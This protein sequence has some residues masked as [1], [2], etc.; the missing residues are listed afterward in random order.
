MIKK[1]GKI[2]SNGF[3]LVEVVIAISILVII[4][5]TAY[6]AITQIIST[7]K[8]LD[9]KR[10]LSI[11]ANSIIRRLGRELQ[12]TTNENTI[13]CTSPN[14]STLRFVG[15]TKDNGCQGTEDGLTFIAMEGGQYLP[16]G[17]IHTGLVQITY[18]LA[19]DPDKERQDGLLSLI[20]EEIPYTTVTSNDPKAWE[21]AK[22]KSLQKRMVF[23]VAENVVSF[24]L[25]YYD[26]LQNQW[27]NEWGSTQ[28][29]VPAMIYYSITLVSPLGS[30]ETYATTVPVSS[31][32]Q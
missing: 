23:P 10:D 17:G 28:K 11:V 30:E 4:L 16:D 22:K 8:I 20:R 29:E 12:L 3:T 14:T 24:N 15:S 26:I 13:I 1:T 32:K 21:D 5:S 9:D 25:K 7:K 6:S 27:L 19:K 31:A 18:R 2:H